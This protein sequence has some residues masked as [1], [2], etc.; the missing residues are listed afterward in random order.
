MT[1]LYN[2]PMKNRSSFRTGGIADMVILPENA[3][4]LV[5]ALSQYKNAVIL[6]NC[7]NTLV[8]DKGIRG[9]VIITADVKGLSVESDGEEGII[10][11]SCGESMSSLANFA[12]IN[13][14]TGLE[15]LYGIPG[16]VGG[17]IYKNAGAFGGE[18]KDVVKEVTLFSAERGIFTLRSDQMEFG[19]RTSILKGKSYTVLSAAFRGKKGKRADIEAKKNE[20]MAS[21]KA[22][23][24]L[25]YPSCG[26]TFKRPEGYFAGRLIE[27]CNLKGKA[28]GGAMVATKHAGFIIYYNSATSDDILKLID[29]VKQTV[30][31]A[32]GVML[33]EEIKIIGE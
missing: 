13:S 12:M 10:T 24:P 32:K 17:G 14:L 4:E 23:Q 15:F 3:E 26:S 29:C 27:E 19:Y 8:T 7:T 20:Y 5:N 11:A 31:K 1:I 16:T 9:V 22:K 21:R 25:E 28:L 6:G 30:Y 18:V 33:E 2:E